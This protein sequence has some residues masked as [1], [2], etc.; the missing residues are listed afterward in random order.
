MGRVWGNVVGRRGHRIAFA[1]VEGLPA[2]EERQATC[3]HEG[4]GVG[5]AGKDHD[6]AQVAMAF[7]I[8]GHTLGDP[9]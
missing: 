2:E 4:V 1:L 8:K 3:D 7:H 5:D 6:Y 9:S